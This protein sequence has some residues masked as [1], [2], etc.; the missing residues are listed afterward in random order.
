MF[1]FE[2]LAARYINRSGDG[3]NVTIWLLVLL[4]PPSMTDIGFSELF[5]SSLSVT[6]DTEDSWRIKAWYPCP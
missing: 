4:Q 6:P 2:N 1:L 5:W 3:A